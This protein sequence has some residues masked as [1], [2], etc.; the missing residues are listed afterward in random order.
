MCDLWRHTTASETPAGA[1]PAQIAAARG[2]LAAEAKPVDV[3]KLYN[4]GSFFDP[5]AVPERDYAAIADELDGLDRVVVESHPAFVGGRTV[6]FAHVLARRRSPGAV[7]PLEVAMGLETVHPG[8]LDRLN[9]RMSL[10]DFDRAAGRLRSLGAA[11]RV[12][13]LIA[14]PFVPPADQ[15]EWLVRSVEAAFG[16]GATAVSIIPARPGN[17][18]LEALAESGEF[19]APT[20]PDIERSAGLVW[21]HGPFAGRLLVDL[22]NLDRFAECPDCLHARRAR[23]HAMNLAQRD[24]PAVSCASCGGSTA[25]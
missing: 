17:G 15:D 10:A 19:S 23:L 5:R 9:K 12:F 11:L 16:A 2:A 21:R 7:A 24:Q 1:I 14:P 22:W 18:A 4:A 25:S 8:A 3:I 13:L 6:R 20:L